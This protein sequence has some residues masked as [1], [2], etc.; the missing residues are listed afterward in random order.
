MTT[1]F[2]MIDNNPFYK[3][4]WLLLIGAL[5]FIIVRIVQRYVFALVKDDFQQGLIRRWEFRAITLIWMIYGSWALYHLIKS[6][7]IVTLTILGVVMIAGWRSWME[8][9]SGIFLRLEQRIEPGDTLQT[10]QG[11]G[12][13]ERFYFQSLGLQTD[14]G[15]VI[16]IPYTRITSEVVAQSTDQEKLLAQTFVVQHPASD[17]HAVQELIT[18]LV[19]RCPW[20]AVLH[21]V[22]VSQTAENTYKIT[23]RTIDKSDFPRL[24]T[25]VQKRLSKAK[26]K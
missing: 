26:I 25:F 1:M 14:E 2:Q 6:N 16:Y 9:F 17:T 8:F 23:A 7:F 5:V 19:Y 12:R 11:S 3:L 13:V 18:D 24:E 22:N 21:P 4:F 10:P 20:T 15:H